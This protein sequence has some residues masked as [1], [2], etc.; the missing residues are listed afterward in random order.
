MRSKARRWCKAV[1]TWLLYKF[2]NFYVSPTTFTVPSA[3]S[4][5]PPDRH[6]CSRSRNA[7]WISMCARACLGWH[8]VEMERRGRTKQ[9]HLAPLKHVTVVG[10]SHDVQV[11][12]HG[13]PMKKK[14][15]K[16][17]SCLVYMY[18]VR[19]K[20]LDRI[21]VK[22]MHVFAMLRFDF[23]I[24]LTHFG[25]CYGHSFCIYVLYINCC[26]H[27]NY[28]LYV[29]L[30]G[31]WDSLSFLIKIGNIHIKILTDSGLTC[32]NISFSQRNI[33]VM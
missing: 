4:L 9:I 5:T 28:I 22:W 16:K 27:K 13:G 20:D 24:P 18:D 14:K 32:F 10:P 6:A 15:K 29:Q 19:E 26:L 1:I 25:R 2:G 17:L 7:F 3:Q 33:S 21:S 12:Q 30:F 23:T 11:A 8:L 31:W